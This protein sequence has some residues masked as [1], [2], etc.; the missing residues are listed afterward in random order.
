MVRVSSPMMSLDAS[1]TIG[2]AATFSKWKGRNYV[3]ARVIPHN[4]K[5]VGQVAVR[6]S[7]K[8]LAQEWKN[9]ATGTQELWDTLAKA[10]VISKFNAFV[11]GNQS[12]WRNFKMPS[13][14][15]TAAEV[16]AAG[17]LNAWSATAGVRQI[18]LLLSLTTANAC[19]GAA[20]FRSPTG[21][22]TATWDKCIAL[23]KVADTTNHLYIDTP[24][25]AGHYYYEHILFTDDGK[26]S[27]ES[28]EVDAVVA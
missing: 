10:L 19:W 12:R 4:P 23:I 25:A 6:A 8:F 7:F 17:V 26:A 24:L 20:I 3:R 28:A 5:S 16:H 14:D 15:P 13:K 11:R 21:T 27:T 18:Q 2:Q 1:G 22:F 9:I